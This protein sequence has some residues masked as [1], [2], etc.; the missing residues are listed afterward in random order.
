[1]R[2][3]QRAARN[4]RDAYE[5]VCELAHQGQPCRDMASSMWSEA[6]LP[7][8]EESMNGIYGV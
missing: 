3:S 4:C 1:M 6:F 5:V 2:Q 7:L 8:A